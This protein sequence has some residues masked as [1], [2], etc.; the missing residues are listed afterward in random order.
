MKTITTPIIKQQEY[1]VLPILQELRL[2]IYNKKK[3]QYRNQD[4]TIYIR[5]HK[6][7]KTDSELKLEF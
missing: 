6:I 2:T 7:L 3:N 4:F 5:P 1:Y